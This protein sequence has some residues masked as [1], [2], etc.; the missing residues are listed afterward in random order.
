MPANNKQTPKRSLRTAK[1]YTTNTLSALF[2]IQ[3]RSD[4]L[5]HEFEGQLKPKN[6]IIQT[7]MK[8]YAK[9]KQ[10]FSKL[11]KMLHQRNTKGRPVSQDMIRDLLTGVSVFQNI[12]EEF[13]TILDNEQTSIKAM[14]DAATGLAKNAHQ[15]LDSVKA[16]DLAISEAQRHMGGT[17]KSTRMPIASTAGVVAH[18]PHS[19]ACAFHACETADFT[20]ETLLPTNGKIIP[21]SRRR[22]KKAKK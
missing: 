15:A 3:K 16:A 4:A 8:R 19:R 20:W 10:K 17:S 12:F 14:V 18:H 7:C 21:T 5:C 11:R 2:D 1:S 13:K 9:Q 22:K 6:K